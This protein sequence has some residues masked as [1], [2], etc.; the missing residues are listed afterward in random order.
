MTG[1]IAPPTI[2]IM[3]VIAE[4]IPVYSLG[5]NP[6]V[7]LFNVFGKSAPAIPKI[8]RLTLTP[9]DVEWKNKSN[10]NEMAVI[11]IPVPTA[12]N[13][14]PF[15][16]PL[17]IRKLAQRSSLIVQKPTAGVLCE[18]GL[19]LTQMGQAQSPTVVCL[20]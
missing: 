1:P 9:C 3:F 13:Q 19:V 20:L 4:E 17:T 8:K 6:M 10:K 12:L 7:V 2:L 16:L 18:L 14:V 15:F 11:P 5:V